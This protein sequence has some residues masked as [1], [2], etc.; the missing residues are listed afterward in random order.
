MHPS[1]SCVA[2]RR[3]CPAEMYIYTVYA[4]FITTVVDNDD[5]PS[6]YTAAERNSE[7]AQLHHV[8]VGWCRD[9]IDRAR[10]WVVHHEFCSAMRKQR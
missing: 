8:V 2:E 7:R 4:V 6:L 5:I 10:S 9:A 1:P 3:R